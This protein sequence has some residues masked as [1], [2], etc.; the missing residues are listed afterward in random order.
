MR[1]VSAALILMALAQPS[2]GLDRPLCN[3][4]GFTSVDPATGQV[5]ANWTTPGL[6]GGGS[7]FAVSPDGKA[8]YSGIQ[9]CRDRTGEVVQAYG[10]PDSG[11]LVP[12]AI[13]L[14]LPD[15]KEVPVGHPDPSWKHQLTP[16]PSGSR[17]TVSAWE[18]LLYFDRSGAKPQL[19]LVRLWEKPE[20]HILPHNPE[21]AMDLVLGPTQAFVY[22]QAKDLSCFDFSG[23]LL[24]KTPLG[25]GF[26]GPTP[27]I[28][29][30]RSRDR[31]LVAVANVG[32]YAI[33]ESSG[34]IIWHLKDEANYF[35]RSLV[36]S[37]KV[38]VLGPAK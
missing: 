6:A 29:I 9:V 24:W 15:L 12:S 1:T 25:H 38:I 17:A 3:R 21:G 27:R 5:L 13:A 23:K 33:D 28:E 14:S 7:P 2:T 30:Y 11:H 8:V 4:V 31:L 34:K 18:T 20:I 22:S 37:E 32:L 16:L 10:L 19:K 36:E 26:V 35:T